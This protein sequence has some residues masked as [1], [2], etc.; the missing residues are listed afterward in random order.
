L[1]G[2][3]SRHSCR[4]IRIP[5]AGNPGRPADRTLSRPAKMTAL[6]EM[7]FFFVVNISALIKFVEVKGCVDALA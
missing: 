3:I 7:E 6:F 5:H 4:P 1:D 2:K